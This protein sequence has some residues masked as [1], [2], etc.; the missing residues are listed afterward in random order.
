MVAVGSLGDLEL[1]GGYQSL[2]CCFLVLK[3]FL[4]ASSQL[5][6]I[7]HEFHVLISS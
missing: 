6:K 5:K 1:N 3:A 7:I 2:R 4:N